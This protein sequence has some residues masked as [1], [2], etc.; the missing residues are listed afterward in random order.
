MQEISAHAEVDLSVLTTFLE[1]C[2]KVLCNIKVVEVLQELINKYA[3]KE[4]VSNGHW[5]VRKIN[6]HKA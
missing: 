4:K 2:I 6:K 3:S 1:T 5:V